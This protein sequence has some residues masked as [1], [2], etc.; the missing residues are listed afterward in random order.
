MAL[1]SLVLHTILV[2]GVVA[3]TYDYYG[4]LDYE[5]PDIIK[6]VVYAGVLGISVLWALLHA[7]GGG[8]MGMAGGDILDGIKLGSILGMAMAVGRL[9]PFLI[10]F[11]V[12]SFL[13][14]AVWWHWV[15]AAAL[16]VCCLAVHLGVNFIWSHAKP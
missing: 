1:L 6:Y 13:C 12:G 15:T 3:L 9:W 16:G 2:L 8:L 14:Q 10:A 4:Q 5:L 11:S 7:F